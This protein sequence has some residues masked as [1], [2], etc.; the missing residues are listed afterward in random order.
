MFYRSI[1]DNSRS[2]NGT[3]RVVRMTIIGNGKTWSFTH[4]CHSDDA[5]EAVFLVMYNSS[6]NG[7]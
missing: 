4:N 1:T 3:Y 7:L 5:S 6:L 2:I